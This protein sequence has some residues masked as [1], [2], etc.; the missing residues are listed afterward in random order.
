MIKSV[1]FAAIYYGL[2]VSLKTYVYVLCDL[3]FF[4]DVYLC[5]FTLHSDE[6]ISETI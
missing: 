3:S 1:L 4:D 6:L 5:H 2:L